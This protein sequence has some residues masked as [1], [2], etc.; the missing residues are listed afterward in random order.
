MPSTPLL[1]LLRFVGAPSEVNG[2]MSAQQLQ[3]RYR[4]GA[5]SFGA[6]ENPIEPTL[7]AELEAYFRPFQAQLRKVLASHR[8]CFVERS[9]AFERKP[10]SKEKKPGMS[11][12]ALARA[13]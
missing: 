3:Q 5:P 11:R 9:S 12:A 4:I 1:Q 13:G 10:L 8:K 7:A 2:T 6:S